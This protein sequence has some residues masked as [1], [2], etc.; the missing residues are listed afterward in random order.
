MHSHSRIPWPHSWDLEL[1]NERYTQMSAPRQYIQKDAQ[2]QRS[3]L[4]TLK[5]P[6]SSS[7]SIVVLLFWEFLMLQRIPHQASPDATL[8][9]NYNM[10]WA[11]SRVLRL[12]RFISDGKGRGLLHFRSGDKQPMVDVGHIVAPRDVQAIYFKI[13]G[14]IPPISI[15]KVHRIAALEQDLPNLPISDIAI[16]DVFLRASPHTPNP[17]LFCWPWRA[18]FGRFFRQRPAGALYVG[19]VNVGP[20][21]SCGRDLCQS[22]GGTAPG[23]CLDSSGVSKKLGILPMDPNGCSNRGKNHK[24]PKR[25]EVPHFQTNPFL[26]DRISGFWPEQWF[27]LCTSNHLGHWSDVEGPSHFWLYALQEVSRARHSVA[28]WYTLN[29]PGS[30]YPELVEDFLSRFALM[31]HTG[32]I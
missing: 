15:L 23:G 10:G 11:W 19:A 16:L 2:L 13:P 1:P 6:F 31:Y 14:P 29:S 24:P 28:E 4:W 26:S 21:P 22:K 30:L 32:A 12:L 25:I 18:G 5:L 8:Q 27:N 3:I 9:Q 7:I 17:I 20:R